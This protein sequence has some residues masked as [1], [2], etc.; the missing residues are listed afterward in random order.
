M[1]PFILYLVTGFISGIYIYSLLSLTL[2]TAGFNALELLALMG[3]LC[4][5]I[6]AYV[7]LAR[8]REGARIA[9]I[10][11]L[12]IWCFFGPAI[13]KTVHRSSEKPAPQ[14]TSQLHS[15]FEVPIRKS[16]LPSHSAAHAHP[17]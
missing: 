16:A 7:S 3:C 13:A 17:A 6:A 10:A 2:Y 11:A 14:H 4:L 1:F 8:P 15:N 9:L 12:M 5:I